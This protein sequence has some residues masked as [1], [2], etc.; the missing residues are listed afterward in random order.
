[1]TCSNLMQGDYK[2]KPF[3]SVKW[4]YNINNCTKEEFENIRKLNERCKKWGYVVEEGEIMS[5]TFGYLEYFSSRRFRVLYSF[6]PRAEF[7]KT[8]D[9]AEDI[10]TRYS[11]KGKLVT[12]MNNFASYNLYL[13]NEVLK[14]YANVSWRPWQQEVLNLKMSEDRFIHW[15]WDYAGNTG[16]SYL[17]RYLACFPDTLICT[18]NSRDIFRQVKHIEKKNIQPK[19]IFYDK[20]R[21]DRKPVNYRALENYK[22]G[23]LHAGSKNICAPPIVVCFAN[24]SPD[25]SRLTPGRWMIHKIA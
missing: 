14:D 20:I 23:F 10:L 5:T 6:L 7:F 2:H 3:S 22:D 21:S 11:H 8:T 17:C 12:S 1:M 25:M 19:L 15:F 24:H 9:N 16:K 13:K 4:V 18:G